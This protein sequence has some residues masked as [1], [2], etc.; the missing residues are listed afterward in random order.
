MVRQT[1]P[2]N[3][4]CMAIV[5]V[6]DVNNL[7]PWIS[8]LK[9]NDPA[10]EV[11]TLD[12]VR[13]KSAIKFALAWNYPHGLFREFPSLQT[14]SSMGAGV[15]HII[16]DPLLPEKVNLVR[17][18][19]PLL[20]RDMYEFTLALVMNRLRMLNH[21]REN[22]LNG[23]WKKRR[24][25]RMADVSIGILG[26]GVIGDF[27]ARQLLKVGFEVT[28]WSRSPGN[29]APYKKYHGSGQLDE[30]L[31]TASVLVCLL[32]LT[33]VTRGILNKENLQKMPEKSWVINLGRGGHIVDKDLIELIDSGHIDGANID[34]FREEPLPPDHPFWK[35]PKI[36]ITPHIASLPLPES[37]APQIMD[38]YYRTISNQPLINV[39]DR[40]R[41]Y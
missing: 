20:T 7:K 34:V 2:L 31:G 29:E 25:L 36:Y 5:I 27:A 32:P 3:C 39:V 14:I 33:P 22:Q 10:V 24:Y 28:G 15:D 26:T 4:K 21:Y 18:N 41:G 35:H 23:I 40:D 1:C 13:D 8:A 38:N 6:S 12:E 19:D 30:F 11:L 37:V 9:K 16:H 17:I